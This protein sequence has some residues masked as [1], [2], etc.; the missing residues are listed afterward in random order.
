NANF[1]VQDDRFQTVGWNLIEKNISVKDV[2]VFEI[3]DDTN[4]VYKF[5]FTCN[6]QLQIEWWDSAGNS[7]LV[8]KPLD[9]SYDTG[10]VKQFNTRNVFAFNKAY[11]IKV[12]VQSISF[13]QAG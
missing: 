6:I 5:P 4:I 9:I 3:N 12:T 1:T 13:V 8:F 11:K 7:H 10:K 2:V